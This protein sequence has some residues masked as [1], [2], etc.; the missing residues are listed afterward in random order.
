MSR[1]RRASAGHGDG[2][3]GRSARGGGRGRPGP[4]RVR[5]LRQPPCRSGPGVHQGRRRPVHGG[6]PGRQ[7]Q[8]HVP[9]E[10]AAQ[11]QDLDRDAGGR[12]ARP[13]PGLGR[14]HARPAGR[15]GPGPTHRRRDRGC[16]GRG[17]RGG[18]EHDPGRWRPVRPALQP[19]RR[20]P[21]VQQGPLRAG[22]HRRAPPRRG[23][24]SSPTSR[25][26][27]TPA[28]PRSRGGRGPRTWTSMFWWAY[29]AV[30]IGG[31]EGMDTA[32]TT[33]DWSGECFVQAG[34]GAQAPRRRS[35][36]SRTGFRPRRT[37]HQQGDFGNGKAAMMLQGQWA[38][39][40]RRPESESK[41]GIA[42]ASGGSRSRRSRAAR[43][44]IRRVR[45]RRQLH[46]RPG[47]AARGR[48][49][50]QVAVDRPTSSPRW[51]ARQRRHP[52]DAQRFGGVHDR[53]EPPVHLRSSSDATF[54]Q[55]TSTRATR[56]LGTAINEQSPASSRAR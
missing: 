53:P 21:L 1:Y 28:S 23:R 45:R 40:R 22:R 36:P 39:E 27:R 35:S 29:L 33:G 52:A 55:C 14:R 47:R 19:R 10:R 5:L 54:A 3:P 30:R 25:R 32:I 37:P 34:A 49:V 13:V 24:S 9:R 20:R 16:Q 48:R 4:R 42:D 7:D 11:G 31:Q 41:E 15:G 44:A 38:A 43:A 56:Q 6:A 8:R 17:Q 50:R 12:P 46:R 51:V 26:S 2:H 18:P